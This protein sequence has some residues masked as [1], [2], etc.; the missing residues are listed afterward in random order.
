MRKNIEVAAQYTLL[1]TYIILTF[2]NNLLRVASIDPESRSALQCRENASCAN[3]MEIYLPL[4]FWMSAVITGSNRITQS[5]T[6]SYESLC[7]AWKNR[8]NSPTPLLIDL[9]YLIKQAPDISAETALRKILLGP[10]N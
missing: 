7:I 3:V 4:L 10:K 8:K 6:S 9:P 1:T 2:Y 5:V